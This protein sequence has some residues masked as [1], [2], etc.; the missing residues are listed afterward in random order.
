MFAGK[1]N[2]LY[3]I[4]C[5]K[6]Y[7][8]LGMI[9]GN[10]FSFQI[11]IIWYLFVCYDFQINRTWYLI[12]CLYNIDSAHIYYTSQSSGLPDNIPGFKFLRNFMLQ[13][14]VWKLGGYG[15]FS[16]GKVRINKHTHIQ[17]NMD[18][19]YINIT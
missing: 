8:R 11:N 14:L 17:T 15:R 16:T 4:I 10:E 9:F 13:S 6:V 2:Y 1:T 19:Y 12:V 18:K 7:D 3:C 5:P